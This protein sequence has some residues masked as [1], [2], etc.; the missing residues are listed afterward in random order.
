MARPPYQDLGDVA[1]TAQLIGQMLNN[2]GVLTHDRMDTDSL[3]AD[4]FYWS[5]VNSLMSPGLG[6]GEL[7]WARTP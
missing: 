1:V 6:L 5:R 4:H 3:C 7:V 2:E